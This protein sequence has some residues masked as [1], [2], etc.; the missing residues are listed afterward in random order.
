M[1]NKELIA[2]AGEEATPHV[3]LTVGSKW[4]IGGN[5]YG[6]ENASF[7]SISRVPVW[8]DARLIVL[9]TKIKSSTTTF[10]VSG[11]EPIGNISIRRLD[12]GYE[13]KINLNYSEDM[14]TGS[15][16]GKLFSEADNTV[17]LVFTPPP[18]QDISKKV[19]HGFTRSQKE[20]VVNAREGNA[21]RVGYTRKGKY[22]Q[23]HELHCTGGPRW[24]FSLDYTSRQERGGQ[25]TY[26]G[27]GI[28]KVPRLGWRLTRACHLGHIEK[29]IT[30]WLYRFPSKAPNGGLIRRDRRNMGITPQ[31]EAPY[32]A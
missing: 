27:C 18:L 28:S 13:I 14:S 23:Q 12:T 3:I 19:K 21:Y 7:G 2:V 32:V 11:Q 17:P 15:A 4:T 5:S 30:H 9:S 24:K 6:W 20:G 16:T 8:G 25:C 10:G 26:R 29:Y 1:L 31:L 22:H